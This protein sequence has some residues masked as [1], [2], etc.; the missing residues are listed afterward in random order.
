MHLAKSPMKKNALCGA[1]IYVCERDRAY[2]EN[3]FACMPSR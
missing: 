1:K 2:A 3:V